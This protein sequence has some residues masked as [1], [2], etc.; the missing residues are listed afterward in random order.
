MP[1]TA[2]DV[3]LAARDL[4]AAFEPTR[5]PNPVCWRFLSRYTKTL[6]S[7]VAEVR[8]RALAAT[9]TP[10]ALPLAV[11]SNGVPIPAGLL[12]TEVSVR[13][14]AR[15]DATTRVPVEVL[16]GGQ[17]L[18]GHSR[19]PW[20][21]IEG[22]VLFLGGTADQWTSYDLIELRTVPVPADITANTTVI[23]FQDDAID[24]YA[25]QLG[26]FL[27]KREATNGGSPPFN[28]GQFVSDAEVAESAF[29]A[30]LTNQKRSEVFTMR[31]VRD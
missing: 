1:F 24:C 10:T 22:S 30:R 17:R 21:W 2:G 13:P 14:V 25:A 19:G 3:I 29:L 11:F 31:R 5:H 12:L 23:P 18:S 9:V 7:R 28:P 27:A 4:H 26:A 15:Q 20:V 8:P 16:P 6:T